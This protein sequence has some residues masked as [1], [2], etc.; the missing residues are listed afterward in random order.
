M[1]VAGL[2]SRLGVERTGFSKIPLF[3]KAGLR[4]SGWPSNEPYAEQRSDGPITF[5]P[6]GWSSLTVLHD[7]E[8]I[9]KFIY[10]LVSFLKGGPAVTFVCQPVAQK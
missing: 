10:K 7:G 2:A 8:S 9:I 5:S 3:P 6:G 4:Q 1:G